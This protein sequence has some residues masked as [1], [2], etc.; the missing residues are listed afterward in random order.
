MNR[1][2]GTSIG[3]ALL[4]LYRSVAYLA[5]VV[6]F[7]LLVLASTGLNRVPA[8]DRPAT[9][10]APLALAID[11]GLVLLF[12]VQHTIMARTWFKRALV[13]VLPASAERSTYVLA[14]SVCIAAI[15]LGWAPIDGTLWSL[16]GAAAIAMTALALLGFVF[17]GLTTFAFDHLVLFGLREPRG[18]ARFRVPLF[19]RLVRHPMMLGVL[20]GIWAAPR[21]TVGHVV[22]A[23]AITAYVLVGVR[24]EERELLRVF[25]DEYVRY[26]ATV[27]SLLPWP[28][29][30]RAARG[31]AR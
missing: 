10:P 2:V 9:L 3:R 18:E 14:S 26:R 7:T 25:G 1:G 23:A 21:M 12:A 13:R 5:F 22:F 4:W 27:P 24:Y 20:V 17:S 19:Y 11:V 8:I 15:A 6:S 29:P 31:Q 16:D 28:R 30:R